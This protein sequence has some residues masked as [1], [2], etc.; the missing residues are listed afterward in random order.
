MDSKLEKHIEQQETNNSKQPI[1][2]KPKRKFN[3]TIWIFAWIF[4][5]ILLVCITFFGK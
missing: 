2:V 1:E 5:T 4:L 3:L